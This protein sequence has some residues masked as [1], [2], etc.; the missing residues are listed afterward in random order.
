MCVDNVTCLYVLRIKYYNII[1][2][3]ITGVMFSH[4]IILYIHAYVSKKVRPPSVF[5]IFA[6]NLRTHSETS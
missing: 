2:L 3:S 1:L 5:T 4:V 6:V